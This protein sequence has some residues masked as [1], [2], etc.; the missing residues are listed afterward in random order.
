[1]VAPIFDG[2]PGFIVLAVL[3]ALAG[4]LRQVSVSAQ[5][6]RDRIKG[7]HTGTLFPW[8]RTSR[9]LKEQKITF[10]ERMRI[11]LTR[12]THLLF[13]LMCLFSVRIFLYAL[14]PLGAARD[15]TYQGVLI[16]FDLFLSVCVIFLAGRMWVMHAH[17]RAI[18]EDLRRR[19]EADISSLEMTPG[20]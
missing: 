3:L 10:Q 16:S 9:E 11:G 15:S 14:E 7:D 20:E 19:A 6:L 13:G 4:Y 1:M 5:E 12:L 18:D 2:P 8:D 17:N